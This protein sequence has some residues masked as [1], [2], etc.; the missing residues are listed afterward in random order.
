MVG[1]GR[2]PLP[3]PRL[4]R[5]GLLSDYAADQECFGGDD[6]CIGTIA[7]GISAANIGGTTTSAQGVEVNSNKTDG[8]QA[9]LA[10]PVIAMG[11]KGP[12]AEGPGGGYGR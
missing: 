6:H 10:I 8:I 11:E 9:A 4:T 2:P 12:P 3:P 1:E 7:E 5:S